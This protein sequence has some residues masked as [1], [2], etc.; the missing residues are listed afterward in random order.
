M[1]GG[2]GGGTGEEI[3]RKIVSSVCVGRCHIVLE[4]ISNL[5]EDKYVTLFLSSF[6]S[7]FSLF[8]FLFQSTP[9]AATYSGTPRGYFFRTI[10]QKHS[11]HSTSP[12]D[13]LPTSPLLKKLYPSLHF[14]D[15]GWYAPRSLFIPSKERVREREERRSG[16]RGALRKEE[17]RMS[18]EGR[19][20]LRSS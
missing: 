1:K 4:I 8:F 14:T 7:H 16:E 6:S 20:D 19:S 17:M 9:N 18:S 15:T 10:P 13:R 2:V 11:S 12:N 3:K 5:Y